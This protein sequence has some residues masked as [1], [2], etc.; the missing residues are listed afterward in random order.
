MKFNTEQDQEVLARLK[1]N[2]DFRHYVN[3]LWGDYKKAVRAA[4][5]APASD[6]DLARGEARCLHEQLKSLGIDPDRLPMEF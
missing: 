4:L 2:G 3:M 5:H 1:V 6:A